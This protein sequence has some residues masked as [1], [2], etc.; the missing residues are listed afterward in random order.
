[1]DAQ[2]TLERADHRSAGGLLAA[3]ERDEEQSQGAALGHAASPGGF[4]CMGHAG[5]RRDE[6]VFVRRHRR[7]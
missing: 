4:E 1:M 3:I 6:G 7:A 2:S 5:V